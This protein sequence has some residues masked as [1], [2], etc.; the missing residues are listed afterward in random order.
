MATLQQWTAGARPRTLPA[1]VA[2]VAVGTGS[3]YVMKHANPGYAVLALLVAVL[4]QIGVN[5]AN[6]YSDGVRGTDHSRVGPVRLVGQGLATAKNVKLAA[7]ISFFW[8][9]MCGLAL[10]ALSNTFWLIL[11]GIA[12]IW[13]AWKYTGGNNPYGYLGLGEV[14]VFCFFGLVATLG[15]TYTQAHRIDATSVLGAV[16]VGAVACAILVVNNLRDIPGDTAAGK[17]TLAVR[18]GDRATRALFVAF[19]VVA[20]ACV[21]VTAFIHPFAAIGALGLLPAVPAMKRVLEGAR[22]RDL[23]PALSAS[24]LASLLYGV[25][26]GLGLYLTYRLG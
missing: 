5:Y 10:V 25:L 12:S 2:P 21:G 6:D 14:F 23:I 1:A 11:V 24:G 3:A 22:G 8:A 16:G 20:L 26:F 7:F 13:A 15:T 9:A 17:R 4:L 18:I 19:F